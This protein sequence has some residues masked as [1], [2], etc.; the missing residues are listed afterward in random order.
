M[1]TQADFTPKLLSVV[2]P[3]HNE[4]D[5][6]QQLVSK[7]MDLAN[8]LS[9]TGWLVELIVVSDGSI[10]LT[11]N[12]LSRVL[13][14][15]SLDYRIVELRKNVGSHVAIRC[16]LT[17]ARGEAIVLLSADGQEPTAIIPSMLNRMNHECEIVW[18]KRTS[19]EADGILTR[20]L[21][22]VFYFLFRV[23]SGIH[24]PERG[25]DFVMFSTSV[26]KELQLHSERN[27]AVHLTL[28]NLG[29]KP[30]YIEYSRNERLTGIS[31]W[32]FKKRVKLA[33]DMFT[34][35]SLNLLRLTVL[36]GVIVGLIGVLYGLITIFR[37]LAF[38][39][40]DTGWAS[41]MVMISILGGLTL[42]TMGIL[43][44]YLWKALDEIRSRPLYSIARV[45]HRVE[46]E[47]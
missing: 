32:T 2:V 20:S 4:Q 26:S 34:G 17:Y 40:P 44:E 18:G 13:E 43:G 45:I 15:L 27:L 33:I 7:V 6:A 23:I 46:N 3:A 41:L 42:V 30:S 25:L 8:D 47:G 39:L 9:A 28:F 10:D 14:P 11:V 16:G 22:L 36:M 19:R 24:I 35:S 38:N 31:K 29:F 37:A 12:E 5:N 21:A 1:L